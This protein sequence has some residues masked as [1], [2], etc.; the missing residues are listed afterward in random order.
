M[1]K[2][3]PCRRL[4]I[5]MNAVKL[6]FEWALSAFESGCHS[7]FLCSSKSCW[8]LWRTLKWV[9]YWLPLLH[10]S[11]C[12]WRSANIEPTTGWRVMCLLLPVRFPSWV[13]LFFWQLW[14]PNLYIMPFFFSNF[15]FEPILEPQKCCA[16]GWIRS[17][18]T[19]YLHPAPLS[20]NMI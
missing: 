2:S 18:L 1:L 20:V 7:W 16:D 15:K 10:R 6:V 9:S 4:S 3:A 17:F 13:L 11:L 12:W 8:W 19:P 5:L 14:N